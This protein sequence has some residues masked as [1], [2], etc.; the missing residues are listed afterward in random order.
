MKQKR[1]LFG[2]ILLFA[3]IVLFS[4]PTEAKTYKTYKIKSSTK[5]CTKA[6]QKRAK[7]KKAYSSTYML[8]SYLDLI[9]K[10]GGGT[11]VFKKG[12]YNI[13]ESLY[14]PSNTTLKFE[15]GV[16]IVAK[17][18][19]GVFNLI[20]PSKVKKK[21]Y[22]KKYNSSKNVKFIGT[23]NVV[24][25]LTKTKGAFAIYMA[26]NQKVNIENIQFKKNS[27]NHYMIEMFGVKDLTIK[28]C[29]FTGDSS[30]K[31]T[32]ISVDIPAKKRASIRT[33]MANDDT[34]NQ[35]VAIE[36]CTFNNLN[37]AIATLRY[38][39]DK[40]HTGFSITDSKITNISD[41]AIRVINW[42]DFK[43][44][45]NE[46]NTVGTGGTTEGPTKN[47]KRAIY[48]AGAV[49]PTV[50]GNH[51]I[52]VPRGIEFNIYTNTDEKLKGYAATTN[53]F[54]AAQLKAMLDTNIL[55]NNREYVI[56]EYT[57]QDSDTGAIRHF[58]TDTADTYYIS[59]SDTPY[60]N[61]YMQYPT[62]N[63]KTRHYYVF[64]AVMDQIERIGGGTVIVKKGEY[65]I[66][67]DI[68]IPSNTT[69]KLADG[70]VMK[71]LKYSSKTYSFEST[72]G[73]F[74]FVAPSF[75]SGDGN[76]KNYTGYN[77]IKNIVIT[78]PDSGTA[79][80]DINNYETGI[81]LV[82]AHSQN[83]TIKNL[84]FKNGNQGHYIELDASKDV[85]I[86]NC[87]FSGHKDSPSANKEAINLDTPDKNTEGFIRPWTS[88]DATANLNVHITNNTFKDLEVAIGSHSY[89][90]N[91][92]HK[93]IYIENNTIDGCDY[94]ALQLFNYEDVTVKG[95]TISNTMS[96]T[97]QS[98]YALRLRGVKHAKIYDNVITKADMVAIIEYGRQTGKGK[99]DD[100]APVP[101]EMSDEEWTLLL[102]QNVL[103]NITNETV[104]EFNDSGKTVH[105]CASK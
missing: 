4:M 90:E 64:R 86:T 89:T 58:Y 59:P 83:V 8:K 67:N 104:E 61:E 82:M 44:T 65:N 7:K 81:G 15:K 88:Y 84:T 74:A 33:W 22:G 101:Y 50:T 69:I 52:N 28:N 35:K 72:N 63:E 75:Y 51:L 9:D 45:G 23:D 16:K 41:D 27:N 1:H 87:S 93:Q 70:A 80:M 20:P 29:T 60:K 91:K 24:F 53:S 30:K 96:K 56:R 99:A 78:G 19:I 47:L 42:K 5:P 34:V 37:R 2:I 17:K 85:I 92:P 98:N 40:Y 10:K 57:A 66:T 55:E 25:D 38:V 21:N 100:Y 105:D 103:S 71:K 68:P 13:Y 39:G 49:N 73:I 54:T 95:N 18:D 97:A 43:I 77:G 46:I 62:Y 32:A 76:F 94:C 14:I 6:Y 12:T 36:K 11:L 31:A 79:T 3:A 26:H 48:L 102:T